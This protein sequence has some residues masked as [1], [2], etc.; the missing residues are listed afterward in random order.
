MQINSTNED[1]KKE[2]QLLNQDIKNL[3]YL[4]LSEYVTATFNSVNVLI[5]L[6]FTALRLSSSDKISTYWV[7]E[8]QAARSSVPMQT[9]SGLSMYSLAIRRI[10]SGHVALIKNKMIYGKKK[11]NLVQLNLWILK[12]NLLLSITN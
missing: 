11:I 2:T 7:T 9:W 3:S 5:L 12:C 4:N 8:W 6:Q 10:P 1:S